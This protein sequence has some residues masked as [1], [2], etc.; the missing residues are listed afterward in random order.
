M[1]KAYDL[2]GPAVV[3]YWKEVLLSCQIDPDKIDEMELTNWINDMELIV[4]ED[5]VETIPDEWFPEDDIDE[6]QDDEEWEDLPDHDDDE[7]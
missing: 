3:N 2:F 1:S 4:L 7:D 5:L 6:D